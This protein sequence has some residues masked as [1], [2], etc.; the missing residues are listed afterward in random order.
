MD[1][2]HRF[3]VVDV[4]MVDE[5]YHVVWV[6]GMIEAIWADTNMVEIVFV[7]VVAAAAAAAVDDDDD[8]SNYF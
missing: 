3:V 6:M 7:V 1:I 8:Y 5:W 4:V 2:Y